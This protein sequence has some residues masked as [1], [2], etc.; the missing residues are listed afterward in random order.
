MADE[1]ILRAGFQ[2]NAFLAGSATL[3][4]AGTFSR[5]DTDDIVRMLEMAIASIRRQVH[6]QDSYA[7]LLPPVASTSIASEP[8]A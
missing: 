6:R 1:Y 8:T 3:S 4:V 7:A 2:S 5:E